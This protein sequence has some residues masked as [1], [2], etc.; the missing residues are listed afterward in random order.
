MLRMPAHIDFSV[1]VRSGGFS[2]HQVFLVIPAKGFDIRI[3]TFYNSL[4][5]FSFQAGFRFDWD[6][7]VEVDSTDGSVRHYTPDDTQSRFT[8]NPDGSYSPAAAWIY[9]SLSGQSDGTYVLTTRYGNK[10]YFRSDGRLWKRVDPH[11]NALVFSWTPYTSDWWNYPARLASIQDATG[12]VVTAT[13]DDTNYTLTLKDWTGRTVVFTLDSTS[14]GLESARDPEGYLTDYGFNETGGAGLSSITLPN[15]RWMTLYPLGTTSPNANRVG[16][17]AFANGRELSFS[18]DFTNRVTTV[19]DG[20]RIQTHRWDSNGNPT[21]FK[22]ALGNLWTY[23]V[24]SQNLI[25]RITDPRLGQVNMTWDTRGNQLTYQNQKGDTWTREYHPTWNKI[26]RVTGPAPLNY[27]QEWTYDATTGDLL[28]YKDPLLKTWTYEYFAD[29]LLKKETSPLGHIR[30]FD[31]DAY[32]YLKQITNGLGKIWK[33]SYDLVGNQTSATNPLNHKTTRTFDKRNLLT[34]LTTPLGNVTRMS[35]D[36]NR[37]L[38]E[39]VDPINRSLQLE[40]SVMDELVKAT[41]A[42]G[43]AVSYEYDRFHNLVKQTDAQGHSYRWEYDALDRVV[44]VIDPLGQETLTVYDPYCKTSTTTDAEGDR[45]TLKYDLTCLL[46]DRIFEDGSFFRW[47]YDAEMR[48]TRMTTPQPLKYGGFLYGARKYGYD[49]ADDTT[50]TW[51]GNHRLTQVSYPGPKNINLTWDDSNR[52]SGLTDINGVQT[53]YTLDAADRCTQVTRA[54]KTIGY[55]WDDADRLTQISLPGTVTCD[56]TYD[57]DSRVTR[58]LWKKGANTLL[59]ITYKYDSAGNRVQRVVQRPPAAAVVEDFAY[60]AKHQLTRANKDGSLRNQYQYSPSGNRLLKKTATDEEYSEYDAA[61][62][63]VASNRVRYRWDKVGRLAARDDPASANPTT[64]DWTYA[65]RLRKVTLPAGTTAEYRYNGLELRT[66]RKDTSGAVYNY[67]WVPQ[68]VFG[69][70][71]V[72]NE[73]DGA[74]ANRVSYV[75]G[76]NGLIGFVDGA[77]AERYFLTDA[78][79]SVLALTDG[80]GNVTDTYDYDEFGVLLS[81]TGSTYNPLRFTGQYFDGETAFYYL[82]NRY[83]APEQGRFIRRDPI[84][85]RG[86]L[87]LY[88]YGLNRPANAIDP[89]GLRCE[90]NDCMAR[91]LAWAGFTGEALAVAVA[92]AGTLLA[93]PGATTATIA[94]A[95]WD[96]VAIGVI[97]AAGLGWFVGNVARCLGE[98]SADPCSW[99]WCDPEMETMW[100]PK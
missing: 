67:Y 62:Q 21:E 26:T 12:R 83:Y 66:Y 43:H 2:F 52:L 71:Y 99:E 27:V 87:N 91:C 47:T 39:V 61:D 42:A 20:G 76:P 5:T 57:N 81:S 64:Y 59:D 69:L 34:S 96:L 18:Y 90:F 94:A 75:L 73:T 54:G 58:M 93:K 44:K 86:G 100:G 65:S 79:G 78:L 82:R 14:L 31:Y 4:R 50:F 98:C 77:G 80:A 72:L 17:I 41:D 6:E 53:T 10:H 7:R 85:H 22:D 32:G 60:D 28:T 25:T 97:G 49:P 92:T 37:N 33:F 36:G 24:N 45:T 89:L 1:D 46:T 74:G 95:G 19:N 55:T 40:Y 38:V 8:R 23:Q 63:L 3:E 9:S 68:E 15:G 70:A 30:Q 11:G 48:T 35:Y 13:W 51:N 29:G 16:R 88:I 56:L 84:G